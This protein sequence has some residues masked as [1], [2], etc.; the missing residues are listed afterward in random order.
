MKTGKTAA[1]VLFLFCGLGSFMASNYQEGLALP[2]A[3]QAAFA[4]GFPLLTNRS[5]FKLSKGF[6]L[7]TAIS[8]STFLIGA[9]AGNFA[10]TA[11]DNRQKKAITTMGV[12]LGL[13]GMIKF[14]IQLCLPELLLK[15]AEQKN[16]ALGLGEERKASLTMCRLTSIVASGVLAMAFSVLA[17]SDPLF[18]LAA[19]ACAIN[20]YAVLSRASRFNIG[21]S[22]GLTSALN[23][24]LGYT[25]IMLYNAGL[26]AKDTMEGKVLTASAAATAVLF[27]GNLFWKYHIK[28]RDQAPPNPV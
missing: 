4:A 9:M 16:Q 25:S 10:L 21:F 2:L 17:I 5:E 22:R 28:H 6:G 7:L 15:I 24:T 23:I 1:G 18:A 13:S 26:A 12:C 14:L 20:A 11:E 27:T 3:F 19:Q 8:I